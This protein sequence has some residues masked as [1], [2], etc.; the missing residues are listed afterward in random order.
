MGA[1]PTSAISPGCSGSLQ[2]AAGGGPSPRA[3]PSGRAH[4]R[5]ACSEPRPLQA[6]ASTRKASLQGR[7]GEPPP[8]APFK[9]CEGPRLIHLMGEKSVTPGWG[10]WAK[11][12]P[13]CGKDEREDSAV[14]P[15]KSHSDLE[16]RGGLDSASPLRG[17]GAQP[18]VWLPFAPSPRPGPRVDRPITRVAEGRRENANLSVGR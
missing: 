5:R 10:S 3:V 11:L 14:S 16:Q 18:A 15:R 1:P 2:A 9:A 13:P 12:P 6:A 17:G 8:A 7:G 4:S